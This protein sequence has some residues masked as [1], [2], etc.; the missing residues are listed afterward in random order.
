MLNEDLQYNVSN[1]Q[2]LSQAVTNSTLARSLC[3]LPKRLI[4]D[5]RQREALDVLMELSHMKKKPRMEKKRTTERR[6]TRDSDSSM[7]AIQS[8][9]NSSEEDIGDDWDSYEEDIGDD[10]DSYEEDIR[11]DSDSSEDDFGDDSDSSAELE[12]I[13]QTNQE[14][15]SESEEEPLAKPIPPK[16][17]AKNAKKKAKARKTAKARKV[18]NAKGTGPSWSRRHVGAWSGK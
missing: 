17:N 2:D 11:D 8:V 13:D 7:P 14:L 5:D 10:W 6:P 16:S 4:D 3:N 18:A 12:F 1:N 9:S 15:L